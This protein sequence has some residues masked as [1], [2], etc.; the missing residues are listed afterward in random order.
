MYVFSYQNSRMYFSYYV[1]YVYLF[2]VIIL[3][4]LSN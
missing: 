3:I 1:M 4:Y 2:Q